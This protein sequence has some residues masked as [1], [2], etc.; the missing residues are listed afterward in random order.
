MSTVLNCWDIC[1]TGCENERVYCR[2]TISVPSVRPVK[3]LMT[4]TQPTMATIAYSVWE[5]LLLTG[6]MMPP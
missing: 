2:K 6:P 4:I 1:A 3:P 5:R